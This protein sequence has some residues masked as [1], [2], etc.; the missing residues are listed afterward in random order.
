MRYVF[1]PA[2]QSSWYKRIIIQEDVDRSDNEIILRNKLDESNYV[3]PAG[4]DFQAGH[5]V[6]SGKLKPA[7]ITLLAAMNNAYV[8]VSKRQ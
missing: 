2:L 8:E 1:L 3:R 7:D 6:Y 5:K 4:G